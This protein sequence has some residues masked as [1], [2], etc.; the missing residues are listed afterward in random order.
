MAVPSIVIVGAGAS[1]TLLAIQLSRKVPADT[2]ITLIE[3][4]TQFGVGL[5]YSTE[6]PNHLVNIPNGRMSAFEDRPNHFVDWMQRQSPQMLN[7][8]PAAESETL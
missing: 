1:G 8:V 7:G 2:R 3:R 4:N 5:A 6:N